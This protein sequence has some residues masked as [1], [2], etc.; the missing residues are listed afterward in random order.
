MR[1]TMELLVMSGLLQELIFA[2]LTQKPSASTQD[3]ATRTGRKFGKMTLSNIISE[4]SMLQLNMDVI[5][6]VLILRKQNMS[7]SM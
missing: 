3:F 7:D 6:I 2:R 1:N 5:K 4:K